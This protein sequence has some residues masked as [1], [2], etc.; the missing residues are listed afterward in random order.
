MAKASSGVGGSAGISPPHSNIASVVTPM[1]WRKDRVI[2]R[3]HMERYAGDGFNPGIAG[4]ARF[5][6][7]VNAAG[8]AI[9]TL[10]GGDSF[11][12]AA[13]ETV[14]HNVPYATG[15]KSVDKGDFEAQVYS[16][17]V[18]TQ[19]VTVAD[20][21][22]IALRKLGISRGDLIET[23][24]CFYPQ[25]RLW[26][27]AIHAQC[28]NL[29]GLSW[30][31]RQHDEARAVMFFGDRIDAGVLVQNSVSLSLVGDAGLHARILVLAERM[32]VDIIDG[33]M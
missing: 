3:I 2:H 6:P 17:L 31:S 1:V 11:E 22:S 18:L 16:T 13:M 32:G 30:I 24:E 28:P 7:I 4:N 8:E 29:Q 20:L 27:E 14:F 5:S 33:T 26:A 23:E 12:C 10:Y 19:D 9:P 21:G 15:Y 25:T